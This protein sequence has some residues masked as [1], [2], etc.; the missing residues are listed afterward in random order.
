MIN[1]DNPAG[2]I[3]S[4]GIH[5]TKWIE[6]QWPDERLD[7]LQNTWW[8]CHRFYIKE[9]RKLLY[10]TH[11]EKRFVRWLFTRG[12][13]EAQFVWTVMRDSIEWHVGRGEYRVISWGR[14]NKTK[15]SDLF[16][17]VET[18]HVQKS[19]F[20]GKR[21]FIRDL[22]LVDLTMTRWQKLERESTARA[23]A[24]LRERQRQLQ[25]EQAITKLTPPRARARDIENAA[26]T[27]TLQ[28]TLRSLC[29]SQ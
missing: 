22:K 15:V 17:Q 26:S 16:D 24:K 27:F 3:A 7:C 19:L 13:W 8:R 12:T 2:L 5:P 25:T 1:H 6:G 20:L 23:V 14:R 21:L 29:T 4:P 18:W 9:A 10:D 11:D 28:A